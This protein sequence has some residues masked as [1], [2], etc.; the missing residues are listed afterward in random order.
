MRVRAGGCQLTGAV[1]DH[2]RLLGVR[3]AGD[4]LHGH[5]C[6]QGR[7]RGGGS[8]GVPGSGVRRP[9]RHPRACRPQPPRAPRARRRRPRA[10][11]RPPS[12]TPRRTRRAS[13]PRR[14][15]EGRGGRGTTCRCARGS[16]VTGRSVRPVAISSLATAGGSCLPTFDFQMTKPHPGS[17]RDQQE[18]PLRF[19]MMSWPQTGHG[20]RFARGMRTSLSVVSSM[21]IVSPANAAMSFMNVLA[22]LGPRLDRAEP[23]LPVA[24]EIRPRERVVGEQADDV[25]PLLG[26]ARARGR[27]D[28]RSRRRSGAR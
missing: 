6:P 25:H 10:P 27:R 23:L 21:P 1:E 14:S 24:G 11:W 12:P 18:K 22:R 17:S 3:R 4:E 20:P 15:A 5:R 26:R 9:P 8:D 19:S 2:T 13:G 28:R 16:P 7:A